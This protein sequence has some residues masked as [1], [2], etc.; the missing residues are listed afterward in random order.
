MAAEEKATGRRYRVGVA[1]SRDAG[2]WDLSSGD[3]QAAAAI[4]LNCNFNSYVE[5]S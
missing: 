4:A 3:I 1:A 2:G 5:F